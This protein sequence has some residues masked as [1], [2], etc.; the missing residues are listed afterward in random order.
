MIH[1][2]AP[3]SECTYYIFAGI[4]CPPAVSPRY[5][6]FVYTSASTRDEYETK[7]QYSCDIGFLLEGNSSTICDY[8]GSWGEMPEC[9]GEI[10]RHSVVSEHPELAVRVST[11]FVELYLFFACHTSIRHSLKVGYTTSTGA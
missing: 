6:R 8:T 11:F 10:L 5:G 4:S 1:I 7:I 3:C 2:S 9:L